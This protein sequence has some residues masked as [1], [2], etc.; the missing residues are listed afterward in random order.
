VEL[1]L[2]FVELLLLRELLSVSEDFEDVEELLSEP[3]EADE[4]ED[5]RFSFCS[6]MS[7]G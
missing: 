3:V 7:V 6:V 4:D 2:L 5:C 1:L